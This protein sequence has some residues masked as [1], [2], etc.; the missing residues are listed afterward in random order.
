MR[1]NGF[2][3]FNIT[4]S[5]DIDEDAEDIVIE[6][7]A[8]T[9]NVD[10]Q[11]DI[12]PRS[13]WE[14]AGQLDNF[15]KNPIVLAY[16]NHTMPIGVVEDVE[17]RDEG[18]FVKARISNTIPAVFQ[19]IKKQILKAFSIGFRLN[20]WEY[21]A[22]LDIFVMTDIEMTELSV[23]SIPCNQDSTFALSKSLG[24]SARDELI[25]TKVKTITP[26]ESEVY[27]LAK[28]LGCLRK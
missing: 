21:K 4:K 8:N 20:D 26:P 24:V 18:L 17:V 22:D 3:S 9:T 6:G 7:M 19:Q 28:Q 10:R 12:I 27:K 23:V 15:K 25:K 13:T 1:D 5:L 14:K 16:H 11:G 2:I